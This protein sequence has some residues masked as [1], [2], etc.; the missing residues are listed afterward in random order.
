[1]PLGT[2]ELYTEAAAT[3]QRLLA[4]IA[5]ASEEI[6]FENYILV[7]GAAAD[8]L[9]EAFR[10]AKANGAKIRL[11]IDGAGSYAMTSALRAR[12]TPLV[13][14]RCF[15]P[16]GWSGL[17]HGFRRHIMTRTHRRIVLIDDKLVWTG[18]LAVADGWWH[19]S[20]A[21]YREA[22]LRI[23]GPVVAQFRIAFE[24]LWN[25][26][27]LPAAKRQRPGHKGEQRVLP[28][29]AIALSCFRRTMRY[30]LGKA[31]RRAWIST[32]Y[33]IPPIRLRRALRTAAQRGVDVRLMLPGPNR[34]DHPAVRLA[35]RRYYAQLLR[36]GVRLFE[37]L[38]SF[39]HAKTALFDDEWSVIGTPNLD[40]WS[41][42]WNH[43]I[44]VDNLH[45]P[46]AQ[47][48]EASFERDFARCREIT[49][50]MWKARPLWNRFQEHFFGIFDQAF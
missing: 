27:S 13:E 37:Y 36:N 35:S 31:Q 8:A 17:L 5:A 45:L 49:F 22:M 32:A 6:L 19:E 21:P 42:M 29:K 15:H 18:G 2:T 50:E 47:E 39:Q 44:A 20:D 25:E 23:D 40:R 38:P 3:W 1:V 33:F 16:L 12:L 11:L 48:L 34:H 14:F 4:D 46:L 10:S 9:V 26:E 7:D 41:N 28:Q 30:R 24:S 43:E